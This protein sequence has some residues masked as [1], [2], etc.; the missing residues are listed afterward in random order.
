M[1]NGHG[2]TYMTKWVLVCP[3]C[4][5]RFE[6]SK[7]NDAAVAEAFRESFGTDPKPDLHQTKLACP[8]CRKES[9]YGRFRLIS[10]DDSG[11]TATGKS[12]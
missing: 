5:H 9:L 11:E 12:A 4:D 7:I 8:Y 10:E 6:H 2:G 1:S 3:N